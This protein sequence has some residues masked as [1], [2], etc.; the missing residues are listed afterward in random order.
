MKKTFTILSLFA[1]LATTAYSQPTTLVQWTFSHALPTDSIA[2]GGITE[3]LNKVIKTGGGTSAIDF[4]KNGATTY[5]AQATG[6]DNGNETKYWIL[7]FTSVGYSNLTV[8]SKQQAGGNNPG[9]RDFKVQYRL[10]T[11]GTWTDVPNSTITTANNF[12]TGILNNLPIPS[13]CDNQDTIYL[14]WI[15]TSNLNANGATLTS[16]GIGKIDD[17]IIQGT[18]STGVKELLSINEIN[19]YPNPAKNYFKINSNQNHCEIAIY[20]ILGSNVFNYNRIEKSTS[21]DVSG[22]IKG[23]YFI[24]IKFEDNSS[25]TKKLIIE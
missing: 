3:N 14:R 18:S 5:A 16:A 25:Q 9:P 20:N 13:A 22:F 17:V 1:V 11:I 6:W 2:D 21:I 8:S 10:G 7:S 15:M 4:T 23:L 24:R 19:I 12:T